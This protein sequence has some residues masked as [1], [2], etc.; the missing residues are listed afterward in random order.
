MKDRW[1]TSQE[2]I[3]IFVDLQLFVSG[4]DNSRIHMAEPKIVNDMF[5]LASTPTLI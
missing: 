3:E 4:H 1:I 5:V 2:I